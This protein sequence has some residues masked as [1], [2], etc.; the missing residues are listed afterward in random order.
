MR[1]RI[2]HVNVRV[3][4]DLAT[5]EFSYPLFL[6]IPLIISNYILCLKLR[7]ESIISWVSWSFSLCVR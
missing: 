6:P 7:T 3:T 5:G 4:R 1:T 2:F